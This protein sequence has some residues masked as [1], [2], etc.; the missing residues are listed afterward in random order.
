MAFVFLRS[1]V[2]PWSEPL[3]LDCALLGSTL[4]YDQ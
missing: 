3:R 1:F 2:T 4:E